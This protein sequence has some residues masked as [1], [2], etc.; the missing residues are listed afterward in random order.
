MA[1]VNCDPNALLQAAACFKC[2]PPGAQSEV[3]T[4]L[5]AVIAGGS[6]DPNTLMQE[7]NCM[8]CIPDGMQAEIQTYLLCQ[9]NMFSKVLDNGVVALVGGSATVNSASASAANTVLL[10]YYSLDR[11]QATVSYSTI[12][13]GT[14]FVITSSNPVDTNE[15][16]WAILK[17]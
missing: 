13:S 16:S 5:L 9:I 4:Y 7:A 3:I 11:N 14:S 12:V 6:T 10:T 17:P 8:K 2:L 1:A 15:V